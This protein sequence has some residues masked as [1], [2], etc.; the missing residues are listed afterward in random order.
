VLVTGSFADFFPLQPSMYFQVV[1][2]PGLFN[3]DDVAY[4][5]NVLSYLIDCGPVKTFP[6]RF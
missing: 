3:P 2:E 4:V 6:K 1:A 5:Q